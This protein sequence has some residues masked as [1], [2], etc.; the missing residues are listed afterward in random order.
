VVGV[1]LARK[2]WTFYAYPPPAAGFKDLMNQFAGV[3]VTNGFELTPVLRAMWTHDE[4]YSDAAKSR[5][6]KNPVDYTVQALRAF[7]VRSTGKDVGTSERE[8]GAQ[9][10]LMNMTLF[11]PPS[12]GGWP[13]GLAWIGVGTLLARL[14]FAKDLA[15]D[16]KAPSVD[17]NRIK[18]LL[19]NA[20]ADPG[21][22]VDLILAY[23]GLNANTVQSP[24]GAIPR[25]RPLAL[26]TAQ[27]DALIAYATNGNPTAKLN[28]KSATTTDAK[29]KARGL[30]AL[31]LQAA[32]NMVF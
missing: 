30:V 14:E 5:T 22:A 2:L 16:G 12:V 20:A 19:G 27:R 15:A 10:T 29:V 3:F 1:F 6:V 28:L 4:F 32:E 26:T 25:S 23:I 13:G 21:A 9:L 17:L 24:I 8:L 11:D 18:G 7:G 31:A